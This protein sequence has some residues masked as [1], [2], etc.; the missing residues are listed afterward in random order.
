MIASLTLDNVSLNWE[1]ENNGKVGFDGVIIIIITITKITKLLC[2][3]KK[4]GF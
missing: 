3:Q 2:V 4:V 1:K